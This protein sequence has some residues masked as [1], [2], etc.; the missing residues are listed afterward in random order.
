MGAILKSVLV[1]VMLVAL[2]A[3]LSPAL[4]P[5]AVS[6]VREETVSVPVN[7]AGEALPVAAGAVTSAPVAASWRYVREGEA[8]NE[9]TSGRIV[10]SGQASGQRALGQ[11]GCAPASP[12]EARSGSA[13]YTGI[14]TPAA[15]H[16]IVRVRYAKGSPTA[17]ALR[18]HLDDEQSP[19]AS[20]TPQHSGDW[21][22]YVWSPEVDLGPVNGGLHHLRLV[23]TG[24]QHG[25]ADLDQ[26]VLTV[27]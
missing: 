22:Q 1:T 16:L 12:W 13:T 15:A 8:V 3:A 14:A 4:Q 11:F 6:Q 17:S 2:F 23:T 20:F 21:E 19:R 5:G 7:V 26:F 24:Q 9:Q 27:R 25:L 10:V 18:I